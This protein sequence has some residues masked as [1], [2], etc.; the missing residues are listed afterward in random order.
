MFDPALT[1]AA[2]G[3]LAIARSA[4]VAVATVVVVLA[5]LFAVF[6]SVADVTVAVSVI[7][8]PEAVPGFTCTIG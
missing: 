1:E 3:V 7:V 5:V 4:C 2:D 8:V 6:V